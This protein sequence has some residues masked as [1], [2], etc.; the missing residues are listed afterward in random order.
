MMQLVVCF[1]RLDLTSPQSANVRFSFLFLLGTEITGF[2]FAA[3]CRKL[4]IYP[5]SAIW[6]N[7]LVQSA[8]LNTMHAEE[9]RVS[10]HMTRYRFFVICGV[11][12]FLYHF[13]PG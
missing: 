3:V 10:G 2:S 9:D 5:A 1:M 13:L 12:A 11:S 4:L 7:S 6:P 8:L